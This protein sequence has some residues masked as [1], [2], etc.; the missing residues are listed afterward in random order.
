MTF[1]CPV[2]SAECRGLD[3]FLSCEISCDQW[4]GHCNLLLSCKLQTHTYSTPSGNKC[5]YGMGHPHEFSHKGLIFEITFRNHP[6]RTLLTV[7]IDLI[8]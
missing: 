1:T 3:M 5:E 4:A 6:V 8:V 7:Q 2:L